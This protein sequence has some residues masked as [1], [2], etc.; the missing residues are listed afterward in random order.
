MKF[1][2]AAKN[3]GFRW[4]T[5]RNLIGVVLLVWF[6]RLIK[7]FASFGIPGVESFGQALLALAVL[8][9]AAIAFSG[10]LVEVAARPLVNLIDSV[11]FG[12]DRTAERPPLT[13]KLARAYRRDL[14]FEEAI[15]E[16][17][18]QLEYHPRSL[19]LWCE[20]IHNFRESGDMVPLQH[21]FRKARRRLSFEDRRQLDF[22]FQRYLQK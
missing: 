15:D 16:C 2:M 6:A 17:E 10:S 8:V 3:T 11:Y 1:L 22:E 12:T 5:V 4:L 7:P 9:A 21:C 20:I 18:R 13:L 19:D 14:R